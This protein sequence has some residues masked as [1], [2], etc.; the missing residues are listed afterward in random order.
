MAQA[1]Q[2][3]SGESRLP[4]G[5]SPGRKGFKIFQDKPGGV[6]GGKK[7]KDPSGTRHAVAE[8]SPGNELG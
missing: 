5:Q 2:E 7:T 1:R 8:M 6:G 3:E 4:R